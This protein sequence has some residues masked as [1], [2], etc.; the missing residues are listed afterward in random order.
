MIANNEFKVYSTFDYIDDYIIE[1]LINQHI[2]IKIKLPII[3]DQNDNH[4]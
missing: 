3:S 2:W 4:C 1:I